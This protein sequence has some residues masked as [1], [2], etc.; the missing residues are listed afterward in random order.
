MNDRDAIEEIE[1]VMKGLAEK[2]F[3]STF[4][5]A[6]SIRDNSANVTSSIYDGSF[7][8][9]V[10]LCDITKQDMLTDHTIRTKEQE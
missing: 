2:Y 5:V 10:G 9:A 8:E 4:I 6:I 7:A 3:I 1:T